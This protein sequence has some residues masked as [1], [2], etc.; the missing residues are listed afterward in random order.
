MGFL[1]IALLLAT[2][3]VV[4]QAHILACV[5][6]QQHHKM[7]SNQMCCLKIGISSGSLVQRSMLLKLAACHDGKRQMSYLYDQS[8]IWGMACRQ[9]ISQ[10]H[11]HLSTSETSS[12]TLQTRP[13]KGTSQEENYK[14]V[15]KIDD[16]K[17]ALTLLMMP[18]VHIYDSDLNIIPV[19][20][21]LERTGIIR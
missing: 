1:H 18:R 11:S 5:S 12:F 9:Q 3:T 2:T 20:V 10:V 4:F 13:Q 21:L 7:L 8:I 16:W 14:S 19:S 15:T 6:D 17:C